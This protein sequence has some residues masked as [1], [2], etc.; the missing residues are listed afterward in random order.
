V[1]VRAAAEGDE[2]AAVIAS[3][4]ATLRHTYRPTD[5]AIARAASRSSPRLVALDRDEIVGTLECEGGHVLGLFVHEAHRRRGVAR[6]LLEALGPHGLSLVTIRE[7]GNVPIFERLGFVVVREKLAT[8]L[9]SD[10]HAEL[11]EVYM[12]R[13]G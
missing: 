7:T 11:H 4:I 12:E 13:P 10:A 1:I 6:A 2:L 5:A 3:A 8:E 9:V